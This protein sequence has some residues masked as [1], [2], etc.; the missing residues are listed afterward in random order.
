M[1]T[2]NDPMKITEA[3]KSGDLVVARTDTIYGILALASSPSAASKLYATKH[4]D[5]QKS[6]II[7]VSNIQDIPNLFGEHKETYLAMLAKRPT[8]LVVS[9]PDD[10][11]PHLQRQDG[12][13]AFRLVRNCELTTIIDATGPLLAPSANPEG[14]EPAT[15]VEQAVDYFGDKIALYVDG[16]E[17]TSNIPSKIIAINDD[18]EIEIIRD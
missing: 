11:L 1:M 10:Y 5:N 14:L 13:L 3:L 15:S 4:R 12:T 8:T 9:A 2:S 16:G 17:V 6:C 18:D 7:L